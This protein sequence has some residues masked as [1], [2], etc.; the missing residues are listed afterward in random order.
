MRKINAFLSSRHISLDDLVWLMQLFSPHA[1]SLLR[2]ILLRCSL[3][4]IGIGSTLVNQYLVDCAAAHCH[5]TGLILLTVTCSC[6]SLAGGILLSYCSVHLTERCSI[7]IRSQM[8]AQLLNS[9]WL[10]RCQLHSEDHLSRLTSDV[11]RICDGLISA[12]TGLIST[13]LQLCLAFALLYTFDASVAVFALLSSPFIALFS[14]LFGIRLKHIQVQIQQ[15]DA[16]HR[17]FLQEQLALTDV[18]KAFQQE[19]LSQDR[20]TELLSQRAKLVLNSS[21]YNILMRFGIN[22]VFLSAY[23][24]AF[25]TGA[26]KIASGRIT[27][28]TM[29]AFLSLVNQVQSPVLSLS[30]ILSQLIAVWAST[31]RIREITE[32]HQ[33][34]PAQELPQHVQSVGIQANQVTF[35]YR[36]GKPILQNVSFQIPPG[37]IAAIMGHSGTGKTTLIRLFLGFISVDAGSLSLT[38]GQT[39]M[40][41]SPP[42][43]ELI[44][45]VPQG[46][47]LFSGT[48]A[49]NLQLGNASATEVQMLTALQLAC[50][51][52]F[53]LALP[54]GIYT[55]IGEKG[56]GLSEGQ[57]QR[58]AIARAL[59][60]PAPILLLDEATSA[61]DEETELQ[62]LTHLKHTCAHR[63]CVIVSHR[64]TAARFADQVIAL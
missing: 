32:M 41:C 44:S 62:I 61:L 5:V 51:D 21:R 35:A 27:F 64:D 2:L 58:I 26:L 30:Q 59:L 15:A 3:T 12:A 19:D 9:C 29:T 37:S 16:D 31:A 22:A 24:F 42:A 6:I 23:L 46:N 34:P 25:I 40:L 55:H 43:R 39:H 28:G 7:H 11:G 48:I 36:P 17:I 8:Y 54:D 14:L 57:A 20:L 53:V 45:Y 13:F 52:Q 47:T 49:E 56:H 38:C 1:G 18:V 60:R 63:T 10:E 33:E 4:A 50:A